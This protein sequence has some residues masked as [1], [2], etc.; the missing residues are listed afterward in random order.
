MTDTQTLTDAILNE[1]TRIHRLIGKEITDAKSQL[2]E[3]T[4]DT[5]ALPLLIAALERIGRQFDPSSPAAQLRAK[6]TAITMHDKEE[7]A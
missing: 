2:A 3:R 5:A 4:G 1:D 7:Q 6:R